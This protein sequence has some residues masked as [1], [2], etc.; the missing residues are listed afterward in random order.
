MCD[1]GTSRGGVAHS[2]ETLMRIPATGAAIISCLTDLTR[3]AR[4]AAGAA[5]SAIDRTVP[6]AGM[7][8]TTNKPNLRHN[9]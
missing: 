2:T 6:T 4:P 9:E 3:G 5:R 7:S 8:V 1:L